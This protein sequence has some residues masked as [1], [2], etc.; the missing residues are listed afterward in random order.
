[1]SVVEGCEFKVAANFKHP[2]L[3]TVMRAM[4]EQA[5]IRSPEL[6]WGSPCALL[7]RRSLATKIALLATPPGIILRTIAKQDKS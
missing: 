6:S 3:L 4:T 1:M 5:Q 7:Q 2:P